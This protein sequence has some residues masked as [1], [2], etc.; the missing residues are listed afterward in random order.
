MIGNEIHK[1]AQQ[2]WPIN[3]SLTGQGLRETLQKI[4]E[5][6]PGLEIKSILSGTKVFDWT[7]PKE[8]HVKEA[9]IIT[10]SGEKICDYSENN[11]HLVGYSIPFENEVD[12]EKLKENLYTLPDQPNAIPYVT[13][14]Y[15]KVGD[16]VLHRNNLI[17]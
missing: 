14:Y 8:W 1:F 5:H 16:F 12:F 4:S 17:L 10:P 3:R 7:V 2:L 15:K 9:Y 11:L 13:S 6:L